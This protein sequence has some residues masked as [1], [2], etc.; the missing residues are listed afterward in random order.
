MMMPFTIHLIATWFMLS[1]IRSS[2]TALGTAGPHALGARIRRS[3][4]ENEMVDGRGIAPVVFQGIVLL[5]LD[6]R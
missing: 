1:F 5:L 3:S 6:Y 2:Y 4:K